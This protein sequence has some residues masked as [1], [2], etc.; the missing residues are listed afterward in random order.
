[1]GLKSAAASSETSAG[2]VP[3]LVL[4]AG[5]R[6]GARDFDRP[7]ARGSRLAS[8]PARSSKDE[9]CCELDHKNRDPTQ[10]ELIPPSYPTQA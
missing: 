7:Y 10:G 4:F 3:A 5:I 1:V 9:G 8:H 2:G 6:D